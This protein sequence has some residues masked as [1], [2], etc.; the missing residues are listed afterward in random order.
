MDVLKLHLREA[1]FGPVHGQTQE[2]VSDGGAEVDEQLEAPS[3]DLMDGRNVLNP[4][5]I[6]KFVA[7]N[8][9][10]IPGYCLNGTIHAT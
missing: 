9:H 6:D 1:Q 7:K 2:G 5:P 8:N 10:E 4:I 3:V